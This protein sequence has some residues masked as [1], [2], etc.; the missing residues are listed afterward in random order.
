[1]AWRRAIV[2][3]ATAALMFATA[4]VAS[5]EVLFNGRFTFTATRLNTCAPAA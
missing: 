3:L 2:V 4:G 1:M 5:A